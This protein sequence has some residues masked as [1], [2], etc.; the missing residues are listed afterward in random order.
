MNISS[1]PLEKAIMQVIRTLLVLIIS[2]VIIL[3]GGCKQTSQSNAVGVRLVAPLGKPP[4][5]EILWSPLDQNKLLVSSGY[6]NFSGGEIYVLNMATGKKQVLAQADHGFLGIRTWS[7]DGKSIIIAADKNTTGFEQGG[8]W[9]IGLEDATTTFWQ[10][11]TNR[12]AWGPDD[13]SLIVEKS[14]R[15]ESG[16][17]VT[18]LVV[19]DRPT[20]KE[21]LIFS[22][23]VGQTILGYSLSPSGKQLAFS[24]G[25]VQPAAEYAI[26]VLDIQSGMVKEITKEGD[27]KDPVWSPTNDLIAYRKRALDGNREMYSLYLIDPSG[28]CDI[29]LYSSDFLLSPTWSPDGNFLAFIEPNANGIFIAEIKDFLASDNKK[30]CQ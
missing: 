27:N 19:V 1:L 11:A 29:K 6:A 17:E 4:A 25:G 9:E 26:F 5:N 16:Q 24:M 12:I 7:P 21:S 28:V 10:T 2:L 8:L 30:Q 18:E 14:T 23:E 20:H 3:A 22:T 13:T 15:D